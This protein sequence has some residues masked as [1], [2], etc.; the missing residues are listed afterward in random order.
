MLLWIGAIPGALP[1]FIGF[2]AVNPSLNF[3]IWIL[4]FILFNWQIK[5]HF[6]AAGL[7]IQR[8]L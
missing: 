5:A 8:R 2:F 6:L 4:F 1:V 3:K 7:E